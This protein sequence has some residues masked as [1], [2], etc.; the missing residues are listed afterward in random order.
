MYKKK[1]WTSFILLSLL[2]IS[3]FI[4]IRALPGHCYKIDKTA[5]KEYVECFCKCYQQ[6]F[7][8]RGRCERCQHFVDKTLLYIPP[9]FQP[10]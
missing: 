4:D 7:N 1:F 3:Y 6:N 9:K 2:L 8:K 10:K 5:K